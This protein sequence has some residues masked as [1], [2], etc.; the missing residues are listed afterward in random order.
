MAKVLGVFKGGCQRKRKGGKGQ[1]TVP[2]KHWVFD[3]HG[4]ICFPSD[5]LSVTISKGVLHLFPMNSTTRVGSVQAWI[6][7]RQCE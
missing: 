7:S 1:N 3:K 5:I 2:D 4:L 6:L